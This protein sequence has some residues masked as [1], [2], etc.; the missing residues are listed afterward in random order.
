[1]DAPG[2]A[3]IPAAPPIPPWYTQLF[4]W[5]GAHVGM[6]EVVLVALLLASAWVVWQAQ[7]RDDFDFA[8]MLKDETGKESAL[9]MAILG[10]FAVST[11]VIMHDTLANNLSDSQWWGYL[12]TWSG[13][14]ILALA[15]NK[16][17]GQLPFKGKG[18]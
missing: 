18:T 4:S 5:I 13:A 11:W 8:K 15:A 10:S 9:N 7:K 3:P 12:I 16:W 1:M 2:A 14:R 6:A 17:D